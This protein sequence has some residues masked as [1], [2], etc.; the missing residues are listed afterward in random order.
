MP[1]NVDLES[2]SNAPADQ[3]VTFQSSWNSCSCFLFVDRDNALGGR[4]HGM[5]NAS[6]SDWPFIFRRLVLL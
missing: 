3:S 6:W 4:H 1:A 2:S 5:G